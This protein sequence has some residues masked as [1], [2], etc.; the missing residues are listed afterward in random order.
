MITR[1]TI[2]I[3]VD[4]DTYGDRS[5]LETIVCDE[6]LDLMRSDIMS[7]ARI[8]T[9]PTIHGARVDIVPK[10]N[11]KLSNHC[12]NCGNKNWARITADPSGITYCNECELIR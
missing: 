12:K 7:G 8:D 5:E 11:N 6:L 1:V 9:I 4:S 2:E 3:D 10:V